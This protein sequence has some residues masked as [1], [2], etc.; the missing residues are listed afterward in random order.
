MNTGENSKEDI[1][2]AL[3]S[4]LS[5]FSYWLEKE[6]VKVKPQK[7]I[8]CS[9]EGWT[10]GKAY[11][12]LC[13][14]KSKIPIE[15]IYISRRSMALSRNKSLNFTKILNDPCA[16]CTLK[17]FLNA[18]FGYSKSISSESLNSAGFFSIDD[19]INRN[20]DYAKLE[21]LCHIL[22]DDIEEIRHSQYTM[23]FDYYS[24]IGLNEG[25]HM[26]I[27]I[28]YNGTVQNY[29]SNLFTQSEFHTRYVWS[30][31][32]A[33]R[34]N[35]IKS[36]LNSGFLNIRRKCEIFHKNLTVFEFLLSTSSPCFAFFD[37]DKKFIFNEGM[38]ITENKLINKIQEI[39]FRG[40]NEN[41]ISSKNIMASPLLN[42][43]NKPNSK[44]I[45][46]FYDLS[47]DDY[48]GGSVSRNFIENLE[49]SLNSTEDIF[50]YLKKASWSSAAEFLIYKRLTFLGRCILHFKLFYFEL[51]KFCARL[52]R[53]I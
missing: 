3:S 14:N 17:D 22:Q 46:E 5:G 49:P 35:F 51:V 4:F 41:K 10:L 25:R 38:W 39:A 26:I 12:D 15:F 48:Y 31:A 7:L 6:I 44:L 30:S 37:K 36:W 21:K 9:R 40:L 34:N 50:L 16:D 53:R 24:K 1:A 13:G 42:L 20:N 28:G 43:I 29:F 33:L 23:A 8:F 2:K 18:R 47:F 45:S 52:K 19:V 27:D 11:R 32:K